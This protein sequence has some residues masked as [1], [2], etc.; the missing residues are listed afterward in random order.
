MQAFT[1]YQKVSI[2]ILF[3]IKINVLYI[4][5]KEIAMKSYIC[6]PGGKFKVM[7][8]AS[9]RTDSLYRYSTSTASKVHS[10]S[11]QECLRRKSG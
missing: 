2:I 7:M 9:W 10:I 3:W 6:F 8:T 11:I 1:F 4:I 5:Q